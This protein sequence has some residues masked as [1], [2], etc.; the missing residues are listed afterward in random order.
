MTSKQVIL[1]G[2]FCEMV[3]LCNR[4][5][6][7]VV[8]VIDASPMAF[9]EYEIPYLGTDDVVLSDPDRFSHI[10]LV[11]VPDDPV[12][13]RR[14]VERYRSA[15][16]RFATIISPDADV[17]P[18]SEL[19][20][21]VVVQSHVVIMAQARISAFSKLNV[22]VKVFH[23]CR[24][25]EFVTIAP[26]ATLLG[27]VTVNEEAYIGASS[28]VL[29]E[30]IIGRSSKVGAGAVVTHDVPDGQVVVGVPARKMEKYG[31]E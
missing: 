6:L 10:P 8:G 9:Q 17:S 28:V 25:N 7:E 22:G 12:I 27:R 15:G 14:I 18:T 4:C 30:R 24:V 13:R 16:F 3:E 26:G 31:Q 1:V 21:G 29:P 11:V 19:E 2:G 20:E 5:N 23:E